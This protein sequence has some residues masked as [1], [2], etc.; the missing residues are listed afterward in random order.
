MSSSTE[1]DKVRAEIN[2]EVAFYNEKIHTGSCLQ[3][4]KGE[5]DDP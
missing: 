1:K 2:V 4:L 3:L 5:K